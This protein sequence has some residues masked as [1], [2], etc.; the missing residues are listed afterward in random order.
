VAIDPDCRNGG[1]PRV[2]MG[3]I[4]RPMP[5]G[6]Y[7]APLHL[8]AAPPSTGVLV[9]LQARFTRYRETIGRAV[10]SGTATR[11]GNGACCPCR[12]AL[13]APIGRRYT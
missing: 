10:G 11:G 2:P 4:N 1:R 8:G 13:Q 12:G 6:A 7:D 9:G 3:G 5:M